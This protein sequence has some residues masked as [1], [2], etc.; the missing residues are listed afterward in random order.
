MS[1]NNESGVYRYEKQKTHT[2]GNR[3]PAATV[4]R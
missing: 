2:H 1:N 3:G 4:I